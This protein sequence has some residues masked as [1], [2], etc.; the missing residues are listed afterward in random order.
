ML[1]KDLWIVISLLHVSDSGI[2][3]GPATFQSKNNPVILNKDTN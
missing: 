1:S 2:K 3:Q